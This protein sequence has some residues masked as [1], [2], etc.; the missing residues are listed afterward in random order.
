MYG[1]FELS[2]PAVVKPQMDQDVAAPAPTTFGELM[3]CV[4]IV[5]G[6]SQ[7]LQGTSRPG[8]SHMWLGS[9]KL[10]LD[11]GIP[12]YAPA[13]ELDSSPMVRAKPI[14]PISF[15]TCI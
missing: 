7:M 10:L 2:V 3:E 5:P 12:G 13:A 6:I 1:T 4:D 15:Y 14:E 11:T 9:G 8:S